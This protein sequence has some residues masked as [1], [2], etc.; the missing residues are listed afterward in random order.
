MGT[1]PPSGTVPFFRGIHC[2]ESRG[3]WGLSR[4]VGLSP[5]S[6][7]STAQKIGTVPNNGTVPNGPK[8]SGKEWCINE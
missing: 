7:A 8:L 5:F 6:A 3:K 2:A 1:V 4:R